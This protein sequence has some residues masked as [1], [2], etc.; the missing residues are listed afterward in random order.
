MTD[1][2]ARKMDKPSTA[3][4]GDV[5]L[6]EDLARAD[7]YGLIARFF[8]L[9]PDQEFLDQI[10]ATGDQQDGSND[11]PLARAWLDLVE[12]AKIILPKL[13]MMNLI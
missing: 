11:A 2:D 10:A 6:P 1:R 4:V 3:E 12:V 5:G 7:L 13:G 8:H 9:P